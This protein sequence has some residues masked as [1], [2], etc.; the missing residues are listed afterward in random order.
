MTQQ[1]IAVEMDVSQPTVQRWLSGS[2]EP[3][4]DEIQKLA[5]L[6]NVP[7]VRLLSG[8]VEY[9]MQTRETPASYSVKPPP[10]EKKMDVAKIR[11]AVQNIQSQLDAINKQLDQL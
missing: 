9:E 10:P 8:P 3:S 2:S 1:Q 4:I 7:M 6:F 5:K 11:R